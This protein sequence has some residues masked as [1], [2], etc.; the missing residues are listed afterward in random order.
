MAFGE[1][2]F[3]VVQAPFRT[4]QQVIDRE[5]LLV[6]VA[7]YADASFVVKPYNSISQAIVEQEALN[8]SDDGLLGLNYLK[9]LANHGVKQVVLANLTTSDTGVLDYSFTGAKLSNIFEELETGRFEGLVIPYE[10][11]GDTL[12]MYKEFYNTKF[13]L[14]NPIG[15]YTYFIV[16]TT[17]GSEIAVFADNFKVETGGVDSYG[18]LYLATT[19]GI[20]TSVDSSLTYGDSIVWLAGNIA[21]TDIGVSP[22]QRTLEGAIGYDT[23]KVFNES[24]RQVSLENGIAVLRFKDSFNNVLA[25]EN[26]NTPTGHDLRT[27][28]IYHSFINNL[29]EGLGLG[30]PNNPAVSFSK[31]VTAYNNLRDEYLKKN[32][33]VGSEFS[34]DKTGLTTVNLKTVVDENEVI[35]NF[36]VFVDLET[37]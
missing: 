20:A 12:A 7:S 15:L 35:L 37:E 31:F 13:N 28:R 19:T 9:I 27:I 34:I 22:T 21:V 24:V 3:N 8:G 17:A 32:Y 36:D 29:I 30:E 26:A 2:K 1:A 6:L 16:Q 18:A 25:I 5:G 33:I 11:S 4:G 14:G 23:V 10:L